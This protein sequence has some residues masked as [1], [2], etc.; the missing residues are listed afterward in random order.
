MLRAYFGFFWVAVVVF[1]LCVVWVT[2]VVGVVC[3]CCYS[4]ALGELLGIK[5]VLRLGCC[6]F[7][8][9]FVRCCGCVCDCCVLVLGCW[10][11]CFVSGC[12]LLVVFMGVSRGFGFF[13]FIGLVVVF[14]FFCCLWGL[15][16][17]VFRCGVGVFW[18]RLFFCVV[19]FLGLVLWYSLLCIFLLL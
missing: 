9:C 10:A 3:Y 18:V 4:V 16:V 15:F 6:V 12:D 13:A 2:R 14:C 8:C 19:F 5:I 11:A 17:G 7:L 1:C